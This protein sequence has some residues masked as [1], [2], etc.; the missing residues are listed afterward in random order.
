MR[1]VT[2][3][4]ITLNYNTLRAI[5]RHGVPATLPHNALHDV[6]LHYKLIT[7]EEVTTHCIATHHITTH[8]M[9][10]RSLATCAGRTNNIRLG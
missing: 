4:C 6:T 5:A 8:H 1:G 2:Q 7:P 3:H 10:A 9:E